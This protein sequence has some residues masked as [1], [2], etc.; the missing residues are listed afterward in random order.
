MSREVE[1]KPVWQWHCLQCETTQTHD[2]VIAELTDDEREQMKIDHGIYGAETGDFVMRPSVVW[3]E[4]CGE[5]FDVTG[6]EKP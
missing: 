5:Q 1:L 3:C 2:Y 6:S 4:I